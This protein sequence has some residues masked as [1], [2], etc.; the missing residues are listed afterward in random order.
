[1]NN[2]FISWHETTRKGNN[3]YVIA[4]FFLYRNTKFM[5][6]VYNIAQLNDLLVGLCFCTIPAAYT[7]MLNIYII[8]TSWTAVRTF[9]GHGGYMMKTYRNL[10]VSCYQDR[11]L[12]SFWMVAR[13]LLYEGFV[14]LS[15]KAHTLTITPWGI[16]QAWGAYERFYWSGV[17]EFKVL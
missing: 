13:D 12:Y 15:V 11:L 9:L 5:W 14:P 16:V 7:Y 1:M 2:I 17:V 8:H 3:L 10:Q 4:T 6:M